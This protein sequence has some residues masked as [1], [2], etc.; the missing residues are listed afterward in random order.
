MSLVGPRP[1]WSREAVHCLPWQR[2]RLL[3]TPGLTCFW[4][5]HGRNTVSF[6]QWMRM[7]LQYLRR[8]SL[9]CDLKLLLTTPASIVFPSGPR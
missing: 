8:Q 7:D 5:V 4:Q 3:V 6:D 9:L 2:Q 1:L